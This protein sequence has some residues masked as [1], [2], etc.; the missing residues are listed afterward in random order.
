MQDQDGGENKRHAACVKEAG[1]PQTSVASPAMRW[2]SSLDFSHGV[3]D[4]LRPKNWAT[5]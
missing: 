5:P 1:S 3:A 2:L 4:R